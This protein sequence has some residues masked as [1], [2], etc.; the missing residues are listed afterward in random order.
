MTH[1]VRAVRSHGTTPQAGWRGPSATDCRCK[2]S[3]ASRGKEEGPEKPSPQS[4]L[5]Q[6]QRGCLSKRKGPPLRH[7]IITADVPFERPIFGFHDFRL[8]NFFRQRE[9]LA[10]EGR[11]HVDRVDFYLSK[12]LLFYSCLW[13]GGVNGSVENFSRLNRLPKG[14]N[15]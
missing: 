13:D 5:H 10:L 14:R 3:S 12:R 9:R 2:L 15:L 11:R 6:P 8:L 7:R 4:R 1:F